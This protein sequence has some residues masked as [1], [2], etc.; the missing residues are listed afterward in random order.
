MHSGCVVKPFAD[1]R[2]V[3]SN[4][5]GGVGWVE[6]HRWVQWELGKEEVKIVGAD[7][8]GVLLGREEKWGGSWKGQLRRGGPL[9]RQSL[10]VLAESNPSEKE[11][12]AL[13]SSMLRTKA[14]MMYRQASQ[15]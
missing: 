7:V 6:S 14:A 9:G 10:P 2:K 11:S 1:L 4:S 12:W 15:V 8:A 3:L 13:H 5:G